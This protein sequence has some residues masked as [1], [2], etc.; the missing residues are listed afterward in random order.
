MWATTINTTGQ[1]SFKFNFASIPFTHI[2]LFMLFD[3]LP[4]DVF[5]LILLSL[6]GYPLELTQE[7]VGKEQTWRVL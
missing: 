1:Y 2:Y 4:F 3:L 7:A 5:N 6:L